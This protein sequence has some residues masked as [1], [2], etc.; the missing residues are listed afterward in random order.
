MRHYRWIGLAALVAA[1]AGFALAA[2][3]AFA[4]PT[5]A[6]GS[7]GF[8]TGVALIAAGFLTQATLLFRL[9]RRRGLQGIERRL[10]LTRAVWGGPFGT[11]GAIWDLS[12]EP[13]ERP[14][15]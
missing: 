10:V 12:A 3:A 6:A 7:G 13:D 14:R 5:R 1:L 9:I 11:L 15:P 4:D 2:V 8:W